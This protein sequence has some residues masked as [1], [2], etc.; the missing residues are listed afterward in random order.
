M[1]KVTAFLDLSKE[2]NQFLLQGLC[3]SSTDHGGRGRFLPSF[4]TSS[5]NGDTDAGRKCLKLFLE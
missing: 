4:G 1:G 3:G 2:S 5:E